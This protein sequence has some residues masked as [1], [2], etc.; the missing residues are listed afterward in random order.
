MQCRVF[1]LFALRLF[2]VKKL[3]PG[4]NIHAGFRVGGDLKAVPGEHPDI[5]RTEQLKKTV[6]PADLL[7]PL[8]AAAVVHGDDDPGLHG[9]GNALGLRGVDG[10]IPA[11]GDEQH[12]DAAELLKLCARQLM[13]EIAEVRE[14]YTLG[15]DDGNE[16]PAAKLSVLAVVKGLD[17]AQLHFGL[18]PGKDDLLRCAMVAVPVAAYYRV[19]RQ[20]RQLKPRDGAGGIGVEDHSPI[21]AD[22]LKA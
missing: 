5:G 14:V 8:R 17:L 4:E 12:I 1:A 13:A 2:A 6:D 9:I 7:E 11:D 15:G 18:V 20:L 21:L 16:V 19:S 10:V 3:R 22:D